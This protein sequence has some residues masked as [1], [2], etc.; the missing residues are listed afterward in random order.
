MEDMR[1]LMEM[2]QKKTNDVLEKILA[3]LDRDN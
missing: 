3:K 2:N 1:S